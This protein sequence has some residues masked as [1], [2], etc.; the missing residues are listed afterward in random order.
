MHIII[1]LTA[2]PVPSALV[3]HGGEAGL[4][5]LGA[6][7]PASAGVSTVIDLPVLMILYDAWTV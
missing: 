4:Q 1:A 7:K 2:L 6:V 3:F 5:P